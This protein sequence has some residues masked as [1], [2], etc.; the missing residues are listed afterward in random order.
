MICRKLSH[1]RSKDPPSAPQLSLNYYEIY[2]VNRFYKRSYRQE[3]IIFMQYIF[4]PTEIIQT[5]TF[6]VLQNFAFWYRS[7]FEMDF[8]RDPNY[9]IP[10]FATANK[11]KN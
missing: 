5:E 4:S 7:G 2:E 1:H 11:A 8:Y 9:Q 3:R 10:N 6:R